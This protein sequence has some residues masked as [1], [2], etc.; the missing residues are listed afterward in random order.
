MSSLF[1][2]YLS[3]WNTERCGTVAKCFIKPGC[4]WWRSDSCH[5]QLL[6]YFVLTHGMK[7][8]PLAQCWFPGLAV[9]SAKIEIYFSDKIYGSNFIKQH[10][11][12]VMVW[13]YQNADCSCKK[14][15]YC[16]II[17]IFGTLSF[18]I[19]V[20]IHPWKGEV[21]CWLPEIYTIFNLQCFH[22]GIHL[23]RS[24]QTMKTG[25]LKS[26]SDHLSEGFW[27]FRDAKAKDFMSDA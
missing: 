17:I 9:S 10:L 27:V 21:T 22:G 20:R 1:I 5:K 8:V 26:Y 12:I 19:W 3:V 24:Q 14:S 2:A 23:T 4:F 13:N 11:E 6:L 25:H 16:V 7:C 15:I 18:P